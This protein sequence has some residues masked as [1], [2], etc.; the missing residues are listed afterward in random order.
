MRLWP[1]TVACPLL[2]VVLTAALTPVGTAAGRAAPDDAPASARAASQP[3]QT[4]DGLPGE[5][6][7]P[8][9]AARRGRVTVDNRRSWKVARGVRYQRWDRTDARGKLRAHLLT[10]DAS[11]PGVRLDH[12]MGEVVPQRLPLTQLLHRNDAVAGI[13][14]G[15]FDIYDT[16]APLGVGQDRQRGFLHAARFT[17]RN[18]FWM[19]RSGRYRVGDMPLSAE[20]VGRPEIEISNVNTP[21]VREGKVGIWDSSW[22]TTSGYSVTDGQKR[23]VRMVVVER[24]VVVANSRRLSA[25]EPIVGR[26]LVGR[27][28]GAQQLR[29]LAVGQRVRLRWS[30]GRKARFAIGGEA[31]LLRGGRLQVSDDRILHPRTAV[32]VDHHTGKV[33]LLAVDGRQRHS[34]GA[35]LVELARIL[36]KK[37]ADVALNLDGGGSTTIAGL[38][39]NGRLRALNRPSDGAQRPVPDALVVQVR[40]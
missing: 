5:V 37:G 35:T 31:V 15:F 19:N 8:L 29:E 21:R 14:G 11:R 16:G 13:N 4:S 38:R 6:V 17:W 26:V 1:G 25:G 20:I 12:A 9:P 10:V 36:K 33:L 28:P 39:R 32:G 2:A 7:A 18:A 3:V 27:G 24:G 40:P 23:R 22:G 34:R 30:L